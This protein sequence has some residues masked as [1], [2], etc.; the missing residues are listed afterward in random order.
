MAASTAAA[1]GFGN[2]GRAGPSGTPSRL[3]TAF[4]AVGRMAV[5]NYLIHSAACL[6]LFVLMGWFGQLERY[7]LYYVVFAIWGAQLIISPLWLRVFRFGP[8]EW[9]WRWLT[10]LKR[11]PLLR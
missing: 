3:R 2:G 1:D 6:T 7:Q 11:P 8:V 4:A 9:L 5:T 10:Y